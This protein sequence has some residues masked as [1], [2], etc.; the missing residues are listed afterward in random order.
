MRLACKYRRRGELV[1][2]TVDPGPT[3]RVPAPLGTSVIV[4]K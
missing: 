1:S 2:S 4:G 3:V